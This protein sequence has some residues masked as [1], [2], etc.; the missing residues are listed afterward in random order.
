[1]PDT[2]ELKPSDKLFNSISSYEAG[3][4]KLTTWSL[5][6]VGGSLLMIIN[7]SYFRPPEIGD[8]CFYYLFIAG[9][10]LIGASLY[11]SFSITRRAMVKDLYKDNF[12]KLTAILQ[13]CNTGFKWQLRFFQWALLVFG[14]WL[15]IYLICWVN[16]DTSGN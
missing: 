4:S 11:H 2:P 13:K 3:S 10:L 15:V 9:W 5:S 7:N 12:E 8:R 1:M 6:I 14:A 16:T